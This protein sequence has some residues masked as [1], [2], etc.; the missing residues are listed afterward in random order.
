MT[1][2]FRDLRTVTDITFAAVLIYLGYELVNIKRNASGR[3]DFQMLVPQFDFDDL[4]RSFV[5]GVLNLTDA[6]AFG[7]AHTNMM[8]KVRIARLE[9]T[10]ADADLARFAKDNGIAI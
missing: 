5:A 6:R 2:Y 1:D 3:L 4:H 8:Q 7:F 9:G 10:W